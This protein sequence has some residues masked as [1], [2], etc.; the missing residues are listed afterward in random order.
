MADEKKNL[1]DRL[2]AFAKEWE[3]AGYGPVIHD[4]SP[5]GGVLRTND[6]RAAAGNIKRTARER[7]KAREQR[8]EALATLGQASQPVTDE[9]V[10]AAAKAIHDEELHP[11]AWDDWDCW[12]DST[13]M[14][15]AE[16]RARARAGLEAAREVGR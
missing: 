7:N 6:L 4:F 14:M 10:E 1:P 13:E 12:Q 15:H 8:D 9:Q 3:D 16:Y 5:G 11:G 2:D